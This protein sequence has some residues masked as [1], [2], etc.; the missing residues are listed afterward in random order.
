MW[1]D[2]G[3]PDEGQMFI[4]REAGPE[5]VGTIGG[6]TAVA[7]NDQIV[8]GIARGVADAQTEQNA[9]LREQNALLRQLASKDSSVRAVV[10]TGDIVS[11]LERQNR[12]EGRT[13]VPIGGIERRYKRMSNFLKPDKTDKING[14]T[15][16]RKIIPLKAEMR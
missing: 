5:L 9:L 11:G 2:G 15:I 10:T 8:S 12:R 7:N 4:A 16:K 3:F 6:R 13:V 1:A 14:L